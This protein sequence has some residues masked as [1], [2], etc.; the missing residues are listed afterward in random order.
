MIDYFIF[1]ALKNSGPL[2]KI[3]VKHEP[4]PPGLK[5]V[6]FRRRV[7][8][9][10]GLSICGGINSPPMNAVDPTDEGI[11]IEHVEP[12]GCAVNCADIKAGLRILEVNDDS[13]LGCT[14]NEAAEM[15]RAAPDV[16][17]L[18]VCDGLNA[19]AQVSRL[20]MWY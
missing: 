20:T 19:L 3:C 15:L 4:Q 1:K 8:E 16:V 9:K 6:T 13:L 7:G 12:H 2:L 14:K 18:L 5:E 11:F 17:R 10:L